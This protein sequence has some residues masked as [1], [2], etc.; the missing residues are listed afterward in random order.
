[1]LDYDGTVVNTKNR[2]SPPSNEIIKQPITLRELGVEIAIAS[3]RGGSVGE[4]PRQIFDAKAQKGILIGYY[5]GAH[6]QPLD[7]DI[8]VHRPEADSDIEKAIDWMKCN[9]HMFNHFTR[10][11]SGVQV[12]I[13]KNDLVSPSEFELAISVFLP[14]VANRLRLD[15]SAHS[16]DLVVARALKLNVFEAAKNQDP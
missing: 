8:D 5:N 2:F 4:K 12:T 15:R 9:T 11:K 14:G 10:P 3:G 16:Y 6:L 7:V 13:R 1:M